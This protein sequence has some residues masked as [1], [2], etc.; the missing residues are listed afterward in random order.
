MP[1]RPTGAGSWSWPCRRTPGHNRGAGPAPPAGAD[2]TVRVVAA[3]DIA[4]DAAGQGDADEGPV[5]GPAC[6]Q[7]ATA[8]LARSLR[9]DAV[10]PLGDNVYANGTLVR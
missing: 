9:P 5:V 4:C 6:R 10:L 7:Q 2:G 3:G 1:A 8:D